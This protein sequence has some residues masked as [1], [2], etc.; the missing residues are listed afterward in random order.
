MRFGQRL[1]LLKQIFSISLAVIWLRIFSLLL[2]SGRPIL[3]EE[4]SA[5][6]VTAE[7]ALTL[8]TFVYVVAETTIFINDHLR[9][10]ARQVA[11]EKQMLVYRGD[12]IYPSSGDYPSETSV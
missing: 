8:F 3:L 2:L 10:S 7:L 5:L 12:S 4:P 6:V 9:R 11:E 1:W